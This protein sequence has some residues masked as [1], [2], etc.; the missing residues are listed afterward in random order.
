MSDVTVE[1]V[2]EKIIE[3]AAS[4]GLKCVFPEEDE[5][6]LDY[7]NPDSD[8]GAYDKVL[9]CLGNHD[10]VVKGWLKTTSAGGNAH[11]Y[12]KLDKPMQ[13]LQRMI[14]QAAMGSDPIRE[15]L[16]MVR[17]SHK[18][19]QPLA[20]FEKPAEYMRVLAWRKRMNKG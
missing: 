2:Q 16:S 11:Y 14:V 13:V 10:W 5:L 20:L 19:P 17:H 15:V 8:M 18:S 12:V 6:Q 7:D 4:K 1:D 3:I 9:T